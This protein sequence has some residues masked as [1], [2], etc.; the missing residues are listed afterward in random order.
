MTTMYKAKIS[1]QGQLTVPKALREQ[2]KAVNGAIYVYVSLETPSKLQIMQ[3]DSFFEKYA[4]IC[5]RKP[6]QPSM[7]DVMAEL[8]REDNEKF[9]ARGW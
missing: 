1:P 7:M 6:G 2:M 9:D 3:E 5:K 8:E 4:G